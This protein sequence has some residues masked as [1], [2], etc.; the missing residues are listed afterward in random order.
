MPRVH[1]EL[2]DLS[3]LTIR[4]LSGLIAARCGEQYLNLESA[5]EILVMVQ[6]LIRLLQEQAEASRQYRT[7]NEERFR[8][9]EAQL[10]A[11]AEISADALSSLDSMIQDRMTEGALLSPPQILSTALRLAGVADPQ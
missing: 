7:A 6:E 1:W 3:V 9:K 4:E 5:E 10:A 11:Q 8:A 2:M